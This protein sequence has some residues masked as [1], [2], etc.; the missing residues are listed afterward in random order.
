VIVFIAGMPRAGSMWT[1]NV[2]RELY[3]INKIT[4]IPEQ[5]PKDESAL[6]TEAVQSTV[7][8]GEVYCIKTHFKLP[9][10]LPTQHNVKIICN[11]R[12]VRDA[13]L[14]YKRFMRVDFETCI[15]VMREMMAATDYYLNAF[16]GNRFMVRFEE[17][18]DEHLD[19]IGKIAAFLGLPVS[20]K[21]TADIWAAYK[22]S[23]VKKN[24]DKLSEIKVDKDGRI[25]G[26]KYQ[27]NYDTV[28]NRDGTYR[29][30][31]KTTSFQ[32]NHITS[33]KDGEWKTHF[34]NE[35]IEQIIS[36]SEDWLKKYGYTV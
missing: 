31:D 2:V 33:A 24:L 15:N 6:I 20:K 16:T 35:Q 12:D 3:K 13:C 1:Y 14:S 25:K 18:G 23:S 30:F 22:K 32:T 19:A 10:P 8:D 9:D 27:K 4:V 17:L 7:V 26:T 28:R 21:Q 36:L 11:I 34:N 5:I 29:I